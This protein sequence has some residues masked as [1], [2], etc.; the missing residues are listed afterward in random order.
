MICK[1][2]S[3]QRRIG[4]MASGLFLLSF[5]MSCAG[6]NG[7]LPL[8]LP[9]KMP[10]NVAVVFSDDFNMGSG[11]L[12][13]IREALHAELFNCV[14]SVYQNVVEEFE[15]PA[16]GEY[17]R[18][19]KFKLNEMVRDEHNRRL[20]NATDPSLPS[21]HIPLRFRIS[22]SMASYDG[23]NVE[24]IQT[25]VVKG[26]GE[27]SSREGIA[28]REGAA[29]ASSAN[30]DKLERAVAEAMENVCNDVTKLLIRGFAEPKKKSKMSQR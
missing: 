18:I 19:I 4:R 8:V 9:E 12:Y 2:K 10:N 23:E 25:K 17:D 20:V 15:I 3:P 26:I 1:E 13:S 21:R 30:S 29:I 27:S 16:N 6:S 14:G 28:I 11:D 24:L 22:I 5:F 7:N